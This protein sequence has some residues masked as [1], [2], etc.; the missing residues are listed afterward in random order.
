L[1]EIFELPKKI[2]KTIEQKFNGSYGINGNEE[3]A[4]KAKVA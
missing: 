3:G 1:T 4:A 2:I